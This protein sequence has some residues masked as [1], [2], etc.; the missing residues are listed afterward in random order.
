MNAITTL[1]DLKA[2]LL[3]GT[4]NI[5][6]LPVIRS[7]G[8]ELPHVKIHTLSYRGEEQAISDLSRFVHQRH[9]LDCKEG[10]ELLGELLRIIGETK[11][12]L[13]LPIDEP[14]VRKTAAFEKQLSSRVHLPPL[15]T[16]ELFDTLVHKNRLVD[17]LAEQDLPA[18]QTYDLSEVSYREI[19][20]AFFPCLLKPTRGSAGTG[21]K[22][23]E[24][25]YQLETLL[26]LRENHH[27]ILQE[28]IPGQKII[29]NLLAREG[30]IC[31]FNLQEGLESRDYSF[32]TSIKF[33]N[34]DDVQELIQ[35]FVS[36]I[37]YSGLA[38]IDLLLDERDG[39]P[40]I[41]DFNPRFWSSLSGSKSAGIDFTMLTCQVALGNEPDGQWSPNYGSIYHM[42]RSSLKYLRRRL[43]NPLTRQ[44]ELS[45]NTDL[46]ER[47]SDPL[48]EIMRLIH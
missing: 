47:L 10:E 46:R 34:N 29:C 30:N 22:K 19:D 35:S 12:D 7:I 2:V 17:L 25:R 4:N 23:I 9:I 15:P 40:K 39:K 14:D 42:G 37:Q 18:P 33:I 3:L 1:P 28:I 26:D 16:P 8:Q 6:A 43:L 11:A 45:V 20:H 5:L 48:P 13:L 36:H 44:A 38:N 24:T 31:A 27:Y 32:S 41:I 21:I